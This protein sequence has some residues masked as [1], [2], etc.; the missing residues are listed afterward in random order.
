M[1]VF[2]G[3]PPFRTARRFAPRFR[4]AARAARRPRSRRGWGRGT[5]LPAPPGSGIETPLRACGARRRVPIRRN[6]I[7][8]GG[9]PLSRF[10]PKSP[11][12]NL[13]FAAICF[14]PRSAVCRPFSRGQRNRVLPPEKKRGDG[15]E[16]RPPASC[17]VTDGVRSQ[18]RTQKTVEP[19]GRSYG[20]GCAK[21][22]H[23]GCP[24][25]CGPE[26][27][28][29]RSAGAGWIVWSPPFGKRAAKSGF[30]LLHAGRGVRPRSWAF[31]PVGAGTAGRRPADG[32]QPTEQQDAAPRPPSPPPERQH[33]L[34]LR[35]ERVGPVKESA[36]ARLVSEHE[37]G[38]REQH[39]Q[40]G[41]RGA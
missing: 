33:S 8:K 7:V 18:C 11:A 26:P 36:G 17:C 19:Q 15:L 6:R 27:A 21:R 22:D 24:A 40:I 34:V 10:P 41:V 37:V 16:R 1:G 5:R 31:P 28:S 13:R 39:E 14:S 23:S 38:R 12:A 20:W 2:G 32:A 9:N 25:K 35:I 29:G 4:S 30:P 3:E